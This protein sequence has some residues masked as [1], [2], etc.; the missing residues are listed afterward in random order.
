[1]IACLVFT[2]RPA[3]SKWLK[4]GLIQAEVK[5]HFKHLLLNCCEIWSIKKHNNEN[6]QVKHKCLKIVLKA[7]DISI[8]VIFAEI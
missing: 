8:L 2:V 4:N 5:I 7:A 3:A 1:M 6:I